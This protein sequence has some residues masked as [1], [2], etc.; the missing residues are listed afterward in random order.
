[1]YPERPHVN[2]DQFDVPNDPH[3]LLPVPQMTVM[4]ENKL[5]TNQQEQQQE[6]KK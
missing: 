1:V 4:I 6:V 5:K 2:A 3:G